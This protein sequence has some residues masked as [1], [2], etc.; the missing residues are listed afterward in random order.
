VNERTRRILTLA[1]PIIGGM[2]SQNVMNL[3]DTAMVGQLGKAAL[4][5]VGLA[6]FANFFSIAV[7]TGLSAGVQAMASRRLGE[8]RDDET[9]TPLNAALIISV[10]FGLPACVILYW[11]APEIFPLLNADP[12]VIDDGVPYWRAR[13]LATVAVGLNFSFRGYWNGVNLS[14]LYMRTLI[15]MHATNIALNYVLIFGKLGL[16]ALGAEGAGLGTAI[17]TWLG[18]VT[19]VVLGLFHA[20]AS[21]FL[22]R[23]PQRDELRTVVRL[24]LPMSVNQL[25]FSSGLVAMFWIIGRIG[26]AELAAATVLINIM[27]VAIL[28]GLGFGMAGASL[29]GQALGRGEP[30][31][32]KRWAWDVARIAMGAMLLLGLPMV[33]LP[34][35]VINVFVDEKEA[36]GVIAVGSLPLRIFGATVFIDGARLVLQNTLNGAGDTRRTALVGVSIQWFFFLPTAYVV[37]PVLSWGL[38]AVWVAMQVQSLITCAVYVVM[39]L[40]G[41]W[42]GIRV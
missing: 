14:R 7:V 16:P 5:A 25:F 27:L 19:Y 13:L 35:E 26:T 23:R 3:V 1:L 40:R 41:G 24:S 37:G 39:W 4:A 38:V 36:A 34:A 31:D 10:V 29:V 42:Q 17:A 22:R 20:R 28:P 15:V 30:D 9:A 12:A 8:G 33:L 21:G 32:A 11:A 6:S 18:S 2:I